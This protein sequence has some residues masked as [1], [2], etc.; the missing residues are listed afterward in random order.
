MARTNLRT[1]PSIL[2]AL[3]IAASVGASYNLTFATYFGGSDGEQI[4]DICAD[5]QGNMYVV[6]GSD[7]P[8]FPTTPGCFDDSFDGSGTMVQNAG[9]YDAI[10]AKFDAA[11]GLVWS[12]YIG[13]P[14]YDR[15]YGV[16]VD[17]A[18]NVYVAGRAGP[19]FPTTAGSFQPD[20]RGTMPG[21]TMGWG[22]ATST[23][24]Q[25]RRSTCSGT[26]TRGWPSSTQTS[27]TATE[28]SRYL[29]PERTSYTCPHIRRAYSL[30]R[31]MSTISV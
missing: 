14:D 26:E 22:S 17:N 30:A 5:A 7:G 3:C 11:G 18:E 24:S 15:A 19:G 8:D 10:V 27:I 29:G 21:A 31:A 1:V 13:G 2:I 6:G 4:R 28:R 20:F 12:T 23:T 9:H 16:E 25:S